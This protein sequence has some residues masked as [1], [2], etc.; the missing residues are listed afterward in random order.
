MNTAPTP[1]PGTPADDRLLVTGGTGYLGAHT[2]AAAL[3]AGY[4]VRTTVRDLARADEV[5]AMVHRAGVDPGDR[6]SVVEAD[7]TRDGGWAE[8]V[9]GQRFVLHVASPF[10]AVQPDDPDEVI[11][12]ARDGALRV[13]RAARVAGVERVVMTSSFAAIGYP[14]SAGRTYD[15]DDWT[16][17]TPD[18]E[19]YVR[20][21]AVA[22][23]AAWDDVRDAD[24]PA[25]V[26]LNPTGIFGP[27]LGSDVGTSAGL[28]QAMLAG[29]LTRA[30]K[31]A[32]GVV[33]VRDVALAHLQALRAPDAAGLRF[34][35]TSGP[36]LSLLG[37][38]RILRERLGDAAAAAPTEE[39]PGPEAAVA[40]MSTARARRVLGFDPRP[41]EETIVDTARSL[42][43][44]GGTAAR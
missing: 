30:P 2:V 10:P 38:A 6:L 44:L 14:V 37:I 43:D 33:D 19:P 12:P 24:G 40:V 4:D 35:L 22:E 27:V 32:F 20:S 9:A 13:L 7:L 5:R 8:A 16:D 26:V 15:E 1:A 17:P 39:E 21:K 11:V 3:A 42:L 23:R 36:A 25:L 34:L 28:V 29:Q 41:V 31:S 18:L